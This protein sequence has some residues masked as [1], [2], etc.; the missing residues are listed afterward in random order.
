MRL[1]RFLISRIFVW[2]FTI[3]IGITVVFFVQRAMPS[4]PIENMI[5]KLVSR[6][7]SLPPETINAMRA[8]LQKQYGLTGSIFDQYIVTIKQLFTMDFGV[9]IANYPTP[10]STMLAQAL[11]Y[12]LI[13]L[14]STTI[15]SW[16]IGNAI[17][18]LA[19]FK[20]DK[21]YSK[22]METISMCIYPTPYFMLALVIMILFAYVKKWFPLIPNFGRPELSLAWI[23]RA[24]NN[25]FMPALSL[26]LVGTGW[27]IISM[28]SISSNVAEEE[29]VH[30]GRLKGLS[31]ASIGYRYVFRNSILTQVTALALHIGAA[32]SGSLMCEIIFSYPGVGQ[33][34]MTAINN[35]DYNL[36]TG[37]IFV[38]IFAV[39]T[40]TLIVDLIYPFIDPRIR[41]G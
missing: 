7:V 37:M 28:K 1:T 33:L 27:W 30:Y 40:S 2:I 13:L 5:N 34:V 31:E 21:W 3:F 32:F 20:K 6:G 16:I 35:S 10:V 39:A 12:T 22:T 14:L 26:M 41:Y 23:K 24:I 17:G 4:D 11:P 8:A 15:L 18:L 25:A 36:L 9:S 29:Y 19:G 38:S